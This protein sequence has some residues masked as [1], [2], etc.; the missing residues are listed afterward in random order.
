MSKHPPTPPS[1][2]PINEA[3]TALLLAAHD[4][5]A[6]LE[7]QLHADRTPESIL[8]THI[9][10]LHRYNAVKDTTQALI[11]KY[12]QLRNTSIA[13]VHESLGLPLKDE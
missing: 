11:S 3:D 9:H 4:E 8:K 6:Y 2:P 5:I 1:S 13:A 10:L 7:S 12:A